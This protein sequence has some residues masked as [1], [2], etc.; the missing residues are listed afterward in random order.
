MDGISGILPYNAFRI[1]ENRLPKQYRNNDGFSGVDFAIFSINHS[2]E[3][4]K[5]YTTLRGQIITR[6]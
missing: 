5:W 1:P 6:N 4:N 2:I 3:Q